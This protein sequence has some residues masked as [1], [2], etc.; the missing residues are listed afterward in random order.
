MNTRRVSFV[1][2]LLII[3][4]LVFF[5]GA[6]LA[7]PGHAAAPAKE[8]TPYKIGIC[9]AITGSGS[10]LGLPQRDTAE[11]LAQQLKDG[12]VGA[13]GVHHSVK[14][15]T[16]DTESNPDTAASVVSRLIKQDEV[17][18]LVCG[19]TSGES[20][21]T[22]PIAMENKVPLISM[23]SARS[24]IEDPK[25]G[26]TRKWLFKV[27]PENLQSGEWQADYLKAKG[28]KSVC[29]L[30]EN[31]GYGQDC[32]KQTTKALKAVGIDVTYS[33]AFDRTDTQFPQM[34]SVQ[35]S[36]CSALVVGAIPPGASTVTVA[37]REALPDIPVIAG[38]GVCNADF[39]KLA[40]S[41]AEG[42]VF[43]C[44]R[45]MIADT[46][47]DSDPVKPVVL[48]Y[49]ADYTAFT[50]GKPISTFGSHAWDGIT[51][52][53]NALKTLNDG[54]SLAERRAAVR[55]YI[56]GSVTN[57]PGV[58]GVYNITPTD[59]MGLTHDAMSFVKVVDGKL[60]SFPQDKW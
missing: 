28:I 41:A 43:P 49:I 36:G 20:M 19:T 14:F 58:G 37:V 46:L 33:D 40:G 29:D 48:K 32:L 7:T 15:I 59:H 5:N 4:G 16:Y 42:A 55:D 26:E 18:V 39:I 9:S 2:D 1:L 60:Q 45:L 54:V 57:W 51:M 17:D 22:V 30:Y 34:G 52:S 23:A 56:E 12:I 35:S 24:I 10:S 8:G 3:A 53:V 27:A 11:M 38:H 21:A 6:A 31:S 50:N 13:D 44:Q 47:P 25:T